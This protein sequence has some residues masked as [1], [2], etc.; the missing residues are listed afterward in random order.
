MTATTK[1]TTIMIGSGYIDVHGIQVYF[2]CFDDPGTDAMRTRLTYEG[3]Q[4][5]CGL[6]EARD[7]AE[8]M[9]AHVRVFGAPTVKKM[10][11]M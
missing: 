7:V 11:T 2:E 8:Q 6:R 3:V 10:R 4:M 1:L 5:E 9:V